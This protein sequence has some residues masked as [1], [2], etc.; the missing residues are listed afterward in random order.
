MT[1]IVDGFF[2]TLK[3]CIAGLLAITVAMVFGNVFLRYAFNSGITIAE[4]LSRWCLVWIT[5]IGAVVALRERQHLGMDFVVRALPT[6][7]KK[8]CLVLSHVLMLYA[9]ALI[10]WGSW[11]QTLLNYDV[12]A[13]ATDLSTGWFYGIGVF[14]AVFAGTIL[15][16]DLLRMLAGRLS[17]DELVTVRENEEGVDAA[18]LPP[19]SAGAAALPGQH[20]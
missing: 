2:W 17:E 10:G 4:E 7:G 5:F 3:A 18:H 9:T 11:R 19:I 15:I 1:R 20:R 6:A 12:P 14:F 8:A 16:A 13:P